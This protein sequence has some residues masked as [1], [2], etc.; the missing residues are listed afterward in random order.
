MNIRNRNIIPFFLLFAAVFGVTI[1]VC[2]HLVSRAIEERFVSQVNDLA[3]TISGFPMTEQY[4]LDRIR[5]AFN[6]DVA[7]SDP[8]T[9]KVLLTTLNDASR[10]EFE[11]WLS[12]PKESSDHRRAA[13]FSTGG[14]EYRVAF[15]ETVFPIHGHSEGRKMRFSLLFPGEVIAAEQSRVIVP[16]L[17]ASAAGVSSVAEESRVARRSRRGS[18]RAIQNPAAGR[19]RSRYRDRK[20]PAPGRMRSQSQ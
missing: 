9:R 17:L 5:D 20:T 16:L 19:R 13:P 2:V 4:L 12:R 6:A 3:R 14:R 18:V 7:V 15:A 8:A 1:A 11:G 10:R